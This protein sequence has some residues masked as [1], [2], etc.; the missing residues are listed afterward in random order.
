MVRL[1]LAVSALL[2][3]QPV[4]VKA[5]D[6]GS[7]PGPLSAAHAGIDNPDSCDSCHNDAG[8][9]E[10][11]RCL[12][13]HD[14]IADRIVAKKGV[15]REVTVKDC[16]TC[17]AE[18]G[19]RDV[20]LRPLDRDSFDHAAEAGF[21][22]EGFHGEFRGDCA[23]CHTSRSF[24]TLN[25]K[26][27]TCH[28]DVHKGTLGGECTTCHAVDAHFKNASRAF[29]KST[30]LP[31]EGRHLDVPCADCHWDGQLKGTPTRCYDC[32]W[33]RRQ[34]DPNRTRLGNECENCHRPISWTAV[35][36]DHAYT[37]QPLNV[38]HRTVDCDGCH[39]GRRYDGAVP[40]DCYSCHSED[41]ASTEDPDHVAAGF[42]TDCTVCH[43]PNDPSW[44]SAVFVHPYQLVGVHATLD[45]AACHA[46]GVYQGTP[47]DCVGCH[48]DDYNA[49]QN[50]N[51]PAAG[52]PTTCE[53]CHQPSD[54][55]WHDATFDHSSY[56]LVGVHATLDC[57][58]C[59]PN[60]VYQGTPTD[61]VGCHQDDYNGSTNPNHPA[62]G[63]PT[64]CDSCHQQTDP[65][66]H[67]ATY[68]HTVFPL[69]GS[70]TTLECNSC[71]TGSVY[72]GLPSEC[73]DC[74]LDDYNA[75][76]DP[77]HTQAGFPTTCEVCHTPTAWSDGHFD[78]PFQLE[79]VHATLECLDCHAGGYQG[80]PTECVG[81]HQDDYNGSQNPN[82]P[83]AGFPTTCDG[84]HGFSDPDW[85]QA[86]YP[87]TVWPLVGAHLQQEC[88]SCH[89]GTV[90]QGLPSEC[91]DC[92]L[93]DYNATTS[94]NHTQAG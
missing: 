4:A 9:V 66:W 91:V 64:T 65:D 5:Q 47:T 69:V 55:S 87:H 22:L 75:T 67:Q 37:G 48:Q 6:A 73:V 13:C 83:A 61:C 59:H 51:H 71:H 15:H 12:V 72:Q 76:T 33:I 53:L 26:C 36:W 56:Q 44:G 80:T 46:G 82:H 42:P 58:S 85:H 62:A 24:L 39:P 16:A 79:G 40:A 3:V 45:C 41:Y 29:H 31:L 17:H 43:N 32:H 60:G 38:P 19:G 84:C 25:P 92:H 14:L 10:G 18:H 34:D 11:E 57:A 49:S 2:I 30:L 52:F 77:N 28:E 20:D 86:T 81:C 7:S 70:H 1:L 54:S 89:T 78:H 68:P 35:T 90:Y 23:R 88:N 50:P 27:V 21:A 94:P 93:D 63:F 74:H 8:E